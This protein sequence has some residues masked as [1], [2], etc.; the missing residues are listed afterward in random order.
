MVLV[1]EIGKTVCECFSV[2]IQ[3]DTCPRRARVH[4]A[5]DQADL[6]CDEAVCAKCTRAVQ[7]VSA[8]SVARL[9]MSQD[10][11]GSSLICMARTPA[12]ERRRMP[13]CAWQCC[14][15]VQ[16]RGEIQSGLGYDYTFTHVMSETS[17]QD[18]SQRLI[19]ASEQACTAVHSCGRKQT[20]SHTCPTFAACAICV[21][22]MT[23]FRKHAYMKHG[24]GA[25]AMHMLL[26]FLDQPDKLVRRDRTRGKMY[27]NQTKDRVVCMR[28]REIN[29]YAIIHGNLE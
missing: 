22:F 15:P 19:A 17:R 18:A 16:Q 2:C 5:C 11:C 8:A 25:Q 10:L 21:R 12:S 1:V 20:A 23:H 26:L 7:A 9:V 28:R 29:I 3:E 14:V 13:S 4:Q 6:Q 27:L 24:S